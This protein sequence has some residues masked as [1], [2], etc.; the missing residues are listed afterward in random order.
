M[1]NGV[2]GDEDHSRVDN[3][4]TLLPPGVLLTITS[5]AALSVRIGT[6]AGTENC[7]TGQDPGVVDNGLAL[8]STPEKGT[9]TNPH[10]E[11]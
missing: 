3:P 5:W 7:Q 9:A 8:V 10:P 11:Q 1:A 2:D 6:G 4:H